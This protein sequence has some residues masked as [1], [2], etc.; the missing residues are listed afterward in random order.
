MLPKASLIVGRDAP[1]LYIVKS[2]VR[3][4]C[5][6]LAVLNR[7]LSVTPQDYLLYRGNRPHEIIIS[8][9]RSHQKKR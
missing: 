4:P 9:A 8:E 7:P 1:T 5:K 2:S 6:V 3:L